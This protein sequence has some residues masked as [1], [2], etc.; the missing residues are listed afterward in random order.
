MP[1]PMVYL[2]P[3]LLLGLAL[4]WGRAEGQTLSGDLAAL[5]SL[6]AS[7]APNPIFASWTGIDPCGSRW[8]GVFC[9]NASVLR[10]DLSKAGLYGILTPQLGNL[11]NMEE[12]YLNDNNITGT[13]PPELG[14]MTDMVHLWLHDNQLTG[15]IP[16]ELGN[17]KHLQDL[18]LNRNNL[19]GN[20]P[21]TLSNVTNLSV[22]NNRLCSETVGNTCTSPPSVSDSPTPAQILIGLL[23][24]PPVATMPPPVATPTLPLAIPPTPVV[25]LTLPVNTTATVANQ[26]MPVLN[27][28]APSIAFAP[29]PFMPISAR[30]NTSNVVNSSSAAVMNPLAKGN[31]TCGGC[32]PSNTTLGLDNCTCV[33][34]NVYFLQFSE[35]VLAD[36]QANSSLQN[37]LVDTLA[38]KLGLQRAQVRVVDTRG[39]QVLAAIQILPLAGL[40]LDLDQSAFLTTRLATNAVNFTAPF[41]PYRFLTPLNPLHPFP[42]STTSSK[43]DGVLIA[44]FF[45]LIYPLLVLAGTVGYLCLWRK[46]GRDRPVRRDMERGELTEAEKDAWQQRNSGI[47]RSSSLEGS[48]GGSGTN[49]FRELNAN[50]QVSK[51]AGFK[52]PA[53]PAFSADTENASERDHWGGQWDRVRPQVRQ[54]TLAYLQQATGNFSRGIGEGNLAKVFV[55]RIEGDVPVAVSCLR[56]GAV[57]RAK[58][59]S[60]HVA[61]LSSMASPHLVALLGYCCE[62]AHKILVHELCINGSLHDRLHGQTG[63]PPLDWSKRLRVARGAA[64]GLA[65]LHE[66][67]NTALVHTG[68]KPSN[69]LV[70]QDFNGKIAGYGSAYLAG[71]LGASAPVLGSFAYHA[72]EMTSSGIASPKSDVFSLG[73]I[74]LELLTGRRPVDTSQPKRQQSLLT[75]VLPQLEGSGKKFFSFVDPA[76][77]HTVSRPHLA[78][79]AALAKRCLEGDPADRPTAAEVAQQLGTLGLDETVDLEASVGSVSTKDLLRREANRSPLRRTMTPMEKVPEAMSEVD[80]SGDD[81]SRAV[82]GHKHAR[83]GS[84]SG[85]RQA[86]SYAGSLPRSG[87]SGGRNARPVSP[88][89]GRGPDRIPDPAKRKPARLVSNSG[90]G[91]GLTAEP[92]GV[93]ARSAPRRPPAAAENLLEEQPLTPP[94]NRSR[95]PF[96]W[97]S[98]ASRNRPAPEPQPSPPPVARPGHRRATSGQE[99]EPP[100]AAYPESRRQ[101]G[102]ARGG[103]DMNRY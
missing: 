39:P 53:P 63:S 33:L 46:G 77:K 45:G 20:V 3:L 86:G 59:F 1:S 92:E 84:H 103:S 69:I 26:S 91:A 27:A 22:S 51:P 12:L 37:T 10:L 100:A 73:V 34:P 36:V 43:N 32:Y 82:A 99:N 49:P 11:V 30:V 79:L 21:A 75:W 62:D 50:R 8:K 95:S 23:K 81:G 83:H 14:N 48:G 60:A 40:H 70:D 2:R 18:T 101:P 38:F 31:A 88:A 97:G 35:P 78:G 4:S 102:H 94:P 5:L 16:P 87:S 9:A 42:I 58:D 61:M 96:G 29:A 54:Y 55:G 13:I 89:P 90:S 24:N 93:R 76:L 25:N 44:V 65:F 74:L 71:D 66:G 41:T 85:G 52:K 19:T 57:V 17:M 80:L 64:L 28:T 6:Q 15:T 56:N 68:I 98:A 72:P 7:F 67:T 47:I